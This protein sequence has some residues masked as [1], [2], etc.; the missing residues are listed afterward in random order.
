MNSITQ[1]INFKQS[2]IKYSYKHGVTAASIVYKLHRKTIY[3]WR[4]K[5]DGTLKSLAKKSR[6]P[7]RS[8]NAHT[9]SEIKM[10]KDYK[11][12][13]KDTGLVVLWVKLRK[14]GYTRSVTSLY[15]MM[16]KLGIY[17]KTPSKKKVYEPKAY[18]QM[19]YPGQRVQVDVKYVPMKCLTKELKE[20]GE[21]Y[22][23][24]TAIDEYTRM[25]V[26]WFTKEHSTYESSQF[27]DE[28]IKKFPFKIE[29]IQTDNGFEFTNRLSYN[30]SI[31]DRKTLFESKLENLGIRHKLIKPYTPRHNGKVERSHRK[32]QER[33]YYKR[34]FVSFEDFKEKLRHWEAEYNNFPMKP[35]GWK[36]PNEKLAEILVA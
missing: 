34:V 21:R 12:K 15:R 13:N 28:I 14:A 6:R 24:Y 3:R 35:L 11:N 30:T 9:E 1:D 10:I 5:Y 27:I 20:Q 36:S 26:L 18:Q 33:F 23:Q 7:H 29:E 2:V 8:P 17:K 4:E 22:Y 32:D 25:R 16:I 19:Q 31:R